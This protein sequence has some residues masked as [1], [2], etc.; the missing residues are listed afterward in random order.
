MS[1]KL[2][3]EPYIIGV[4]F[5]QEPRVR[6]SF[7]NYSWFN[8]RSLVSVLPKTVAKSPPRGRQYLDIFSFFASR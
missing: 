7:D 6:D 4:Q 2:V 5:K 8:H 1:E 3:T